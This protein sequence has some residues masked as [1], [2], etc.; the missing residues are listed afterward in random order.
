MTTRLTGP[1]IG[2][3]RT[4]LRA[5]F[6]RDRFGELLLYRLDRHLDDYVGSSDDYLTELRK[7]LVRA[8]AEL[9]WRDLIVAARAAASRD[10]GLQLF[11]QRFDLAPGVTGP[12]GE[13]LADD[14]QL[15]LKIR[16]AGAMFDI[17]QWRAR[18]GEIE[19]QVCKIETVGGSGTGLLVGPSTV[20]TN[21][22]VMASTIQSPQLAAQ[23]VVRFDYKYTATGRQLMTGT[24][25]RLAADWLVDWTPYSP[26]DVAAGPATGVMAEPGD[27]ELD[28]A[29]VRLATRAGD[30][31][32]GGPTGDP[33]AVGRGWMRLPAEDYDFTASP[34]LYIAQHP[35]GAPMKVAVDT[36]A[37]VGVNRGGTRVRYTTTTLP[38]SSGSPCFGPNW[39]WVALHHSGD[40]R[41]RQGT[42]PEYNQG[43]PISAIRRATT[44]RGTGDAFGS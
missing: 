15:E 28:Y 12:A 11:G 2:E 16:Q 5:A 41:Y 44:A 17:A 25:H 29:L 37:I 36:E 33:D 8:N 34:A 19:G 3:L 14:R 38:G 23:V 26:L 43:I 32:V 1:E 42:P 22:H 18:L 21:Y 10:A 35:D 6:T 13:A 31:P 27:D 40:P 24:P 30:E 9:W 4:L 39:E 20:L 7:V